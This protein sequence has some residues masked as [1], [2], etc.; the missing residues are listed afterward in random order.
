MATEKSTRCVR[1]LR[2]APFEEFRLPDEGRQWKSNARNRQALANFLATYADGDGTRIFPSAETMTKHFGW[3]RAT[4]FRLLADLRALQLLGD[5]TGLHG[6]QGTAVRK[7]DVVGFRKKT[8]TG[9]SALVQNAF[10]GVAGSDVKESQTQVQGVSN[11]GQGV[12]NSGQGVSNSRLT[13]PPRFTA[14]ETATAT[15]TNSESEQQAGGWQLLEKKHSA[16]MGFMKKHRADFQ[17]LIDE[18]GFDV[19]DNA[20]LAALEE[21]NLE[22]VKSVPG[23]VLH[24]L[25]QKLPAELQNRKAAE[26]EKKERACIEASIE[27]QR[28][29][30]IARMGGTL[31]VNEDARTP[32]QFMADE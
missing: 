25:G 20:V 12:S 27:R 7:M 13:Q 26:L 8:F 19:V 16:T 32:E 3:G 28:Q 11:S 23:C 4:T 21:G 31:G 9:S 2:D 15:A 5:K 17:K 6:K 1:D 22:S 14:T 10:Q 18:H 24:R 29:E 30:V